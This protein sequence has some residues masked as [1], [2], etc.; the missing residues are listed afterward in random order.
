MTVEDSA[1]SS[2][3]KPLIYNHFSFI[4]FILLFLFIYFVIYFNLVSCNSVI[5]FAVHHI[6]PNKQTNKQK[7][8]K[9]TDKKEQKQ[10]YI[11]W[12]GEL[13]KLT[14]HHANLSLCAKSRKSNDAKSIKWPK[15]SIWEIF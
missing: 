12:T 15:T 11:D 9:K 6:T 13:K 1:A 5:R 3:Q 2:I 7:F 8:N 4:S 10:E 14:R